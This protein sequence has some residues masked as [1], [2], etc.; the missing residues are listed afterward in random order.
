MP[1]THVPV[2]TRQVMGRLAPQP[3]DVVIDCTLGY[4]GHA[5]KFIRHIRPTGRLIGMDID[6]SQ[7]QKTIYRL[8]KLDANVT[9]CRRNFAEIDHV[10]TDENIDAADIIFADVGVSSM[11]VDDACRGISYRADGPLDMRMDSRLE[12]TGADLLAELSQD[13]LS[14]ALWN[15]SDEPDHETIA[16]WIVAQQHTNP[17]TTVLQLV[18]L[19]FN[20]KGLTEK[21]WKKKRKQAPFGSLHPAARTFQ[22][23]RIMV[24]D[25]LNNLQRLLAV[26]PGC[27]GPG[28]RIGV[29]SFHS[30]EDRLVKTAFD[31]GHKNGTYAAIATKALT[32]RISEIVRNPRCASAKFRWAQKG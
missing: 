13:Q 26:A 28:G 24:N 10:M 11:Q 30:G 14:T 17:I 1:G 6:D 18:R 25:E 20:A 22:A 9:G 31:D 12:R 29:I 23:V 4:G 19:I 15:L 32:P 16:Q 2:M 21:T 7:L 8:A 3:G 5:E 27:L